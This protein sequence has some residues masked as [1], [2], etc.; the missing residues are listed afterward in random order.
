MTGKERCRTHNYNDEIGNGLNRLSALYLL[1]ISFY[2]AGVSH[3]GT[4]EG[5]S[6]ISAGVHPNATGARS[7]LA[8]LAKRQSG[9]IAKAKK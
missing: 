3:L 4:I 6:V 1:P 7:D 8:L 2:M 9:S 5:S